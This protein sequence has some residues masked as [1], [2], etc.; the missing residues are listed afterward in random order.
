[1]GATKASA[2]LAAAAMKKRYGED[3]YAKI[4]SLGGKASKTGG[5]AGRP[6]LAREYGAIGGRISKRHKGDTKK[7]KE[8]T[9]V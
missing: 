5:F 4:G 6:D 3:Y 2:K 9:D 8:A 7:K 1:M